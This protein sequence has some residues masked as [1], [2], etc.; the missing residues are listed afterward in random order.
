MISVSF[1]IISV[2]GTTVVN[3]YHLP[4]IPS[5]CDSVYV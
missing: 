5:K 4:H 3:C 2:V 1:E